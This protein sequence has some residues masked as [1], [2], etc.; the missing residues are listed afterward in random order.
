MLSQETSKKDFFVA[1]LMYMLL[2]IVFIGASLVME[3]MDVPF[4][5]SIL[6]IQYGIVLLPILILTKYRG[7]SIRNTFRFKKISIKTGIKS[8]LL[9]IFA[10]PIAW[11]LNIIVNIILAHLGLLLDQSMP[12]GS[13]FGN[14]FFILL[15]ISISPGIC[16]EVFFRGLM[17]NAYDGVMSQRKTI[18][19]TGILF[20]VFHFN[21]QNLLLPTFLGMVFAWLVYHTG[22]IFSSMIGHMTF[23]AIGATV[24]YISM[25]SQQTQVTV[26][27]ASQVIVE[28]GHYALIFFGI[29]SLIAAPFM[30]IIGK[31]IKRDHLSIDV[32]DEII[33]SGITHK[34]LDVQGEMLVVLVEDEEKNIRRETL[35]NLAYEHIK[36][37]TEKEVLHTSKMNKVFVGV[38]FLI[39]LTL[40]TLAYF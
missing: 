16:E 38:V 27:N 40:M 28:Q 23:N 33:I 7:Y 31:S 1:N 15:L 29:L 35:K 11:T 13:G 32:E 12:L 17:F 26:D 30:I 2:A 19:L 3:I 5:M 36:S 14:Y 34:V 39:Y 6:I 8:L 4:K 25:N 21:L 20:G 9:T 18:I 37:R 10:L 24:S 22:S